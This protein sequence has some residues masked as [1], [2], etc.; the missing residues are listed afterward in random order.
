M[1]PGVRPRLQV[2]VI[3]CYRAWLVAGG[4]PKLLGAMQKLPAS[5][6]PSLAPTAEHLAKVIPGFDALASLDLGRL[7]LRLFKVLL[8]RHLA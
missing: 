5:S 4:V 6:A 7:A 8:Q 2:R 1:P 3:N